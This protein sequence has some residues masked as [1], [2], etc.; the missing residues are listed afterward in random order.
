LEKTEFQQ[1]IF[2][3]TMKQEEAHA[4]LKSESFVAKVREAKDNLG[5]TNY[6]PK[7]SRD[8]LLRAMNVL[9]CVE[10]LVAK[11]IH[12]LG[13]KIYFWREQLQ[14]ASWMKKEV[15]TAILN[16][17]HDFDV[18]AEELHLGKLSL[19]TPS[20][21]QLLLCDGVSPHFHH[22]LTL[23]ECRRWLIRGNRLEVQGILTEEEFH[24]RFCSTWNQTQNI[25]GKDALTIIS[26]AQTTDLLQVEP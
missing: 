18:R 17:L 14:S 4:L 3:N 22:A 25:P 1:I 8:V 23:C 26:Y 10:P 13:D 5:T 16:Q 24:Q 7:Q 21:A 6:L 2:N 19:K 15:Q 12:P 9:A 11:P 20:I